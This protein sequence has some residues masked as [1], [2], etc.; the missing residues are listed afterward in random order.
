MEFSGTTIESLSVRN[1]SIFPTLWVPSLI[2][3][4]INSCIWCYHWF[5][6]GCLNL[7]WLLDGRKND[8]VQ[9]GCGSW[10]KEWCHPSWCDDI[11]LCWG[12]YTVLFSC[13]SYVSSRIIILMY[14]LLLILYLLQ[15]RTS[16]PFE[17]VYSDGNARYDHM[18]L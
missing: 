11:K 1:H 18:V 2:E 8:I 5:I 14:V 10:G 15:N 9:H 6:N 4:K 12:M 7:F 16:V 3:I 13:K 17:P